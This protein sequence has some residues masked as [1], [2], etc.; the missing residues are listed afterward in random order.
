MQFVSVLNIIPAV[1]AVIYSVIDTGTLAYG[2]IDAGARY[3]ASSSLM[4]RVRPLRLLNGS[5]LLTSAAE[6]AF[7]SAGSTRKPRQRAYFLACSYISVKCN[8]HVPET[9]SFRGPCL[10]RDVVC[11]IRSVLSIS[12][13]KVVQ[14]RGRIQLK[15]VLCG[16]RGMVPPSVWVN[17]YWRDCNIPHPPH[18]IPLLH[19]PYWLIHAGL[20]IWSLIQLLKKCKQTSKY[21]RSLFYP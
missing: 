11:W 17:F 15:C 12:E 14:R 20:N 5:V 7:N 1:S 3:L 4:R 16:S 21:T 10:V 9:C 6:I 18:P 19:K 2:T 8:V 13:G